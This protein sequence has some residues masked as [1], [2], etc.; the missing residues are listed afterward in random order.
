MMLGGSGVHRHL[1]PQITLMGGV[2]CWP[3]FTPYIIPQA[4]NKA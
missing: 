4:E 1:K 2:L 3:G